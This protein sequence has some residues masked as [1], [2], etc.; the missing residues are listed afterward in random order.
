MRDQQHVEPRAV[1]PVHG[2]R[3]AVERDGALLRDVAGE[4]IG[5]FEDEPGGFAFGLDG[6]DPRRAVDMAR[7]DMPAEFVADLQCAFRD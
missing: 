4:V 1:D 5:R 6:D 3:R 2:E 7:H